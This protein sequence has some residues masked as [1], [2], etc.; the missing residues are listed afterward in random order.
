MYIIETDQDLG[1]GAIVPGAIV[2][3]AIVP[4]AIVPGALDYLN[5]IYTVTHRIKYFT[6]HVF[7]NSLK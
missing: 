6:L 2:P 7:S 3:G 4:G 5:I 1:P